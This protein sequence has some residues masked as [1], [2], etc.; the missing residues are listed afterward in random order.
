MEDRVTSHRRRH[1]NRGSRK[2]GGACRDLKKTVLTEGVACARVLWSGAGAQVG[3]E[4]SG[5]SEAPVPWSVWRSEEMMQKRVL[6][7]L[8]GLWLLLL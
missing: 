4:A 8:Q 6:G 1:V 3:E 2:P 7:L 5:M